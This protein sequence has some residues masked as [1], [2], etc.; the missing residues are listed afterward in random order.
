MRAFFSAAAV[1]GLLVAGSANAALVAYNNIV[2]AT[3]ADQGGSIPLSVPFGSTRAAPVGQ[4]FTVS[5]DTRITALTL[6]LQDTVSDSGSVL[7]YLVPDNGSGMFPAHTGGDTLTN[8]LKL[9]TLSD[10]AIFT[11]SNGKGCSFGGSTPAVMSCNTVLPLS[12]GITAGN[13]WIVLAS[14]AD[15]NNG[16][17]GVDSTAV[18]WRD[19]ENVPPNGF[20][21]IGTTGETRISTHLVTD[22][23]SFPV[24]SNFTNGEMEMKVNTPE[25]ATMALLG[26]G[27]MGLGLFRRKVRKS[28]D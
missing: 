3:T 8:P 21:G 15:S 14:G 1:A 20:T 28:P 12:T 9:G 22:G 6:R 26:A 4:E 25:P 11:T 10:A 19:D 2:N 13:W 23:G 17:G 18:W 16:N 7:V 24:M 27:L 5:A